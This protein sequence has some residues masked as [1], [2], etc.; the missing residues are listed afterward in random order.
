METFDIETLLNESSYPCIS[1]LL[2]TDSLHQL[3]QCA[4]EAESLMRKIDVPEETIRK[5]IRE[6][7]NVDAT[8]LQYDAR[9]FGIFASSRI[10]A[11]V[12]FPFRVSKR[13][14]IDQD[15]DKEYLLDLMEIQ[16]VPV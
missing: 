13:L 9:G 3:R 15:F 7:R 8:S 5:I 1:I 4:S 14:C 10:V 2:P 11:V 16:A 12:P 6:L